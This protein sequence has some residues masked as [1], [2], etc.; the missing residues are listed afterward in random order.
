[1]TWGMYL[2]S[3]W[4]LAHWHVCPLRHIHPVRWWMNVCVCVCVCVWGGVC[5]C[6]FVCVCVVCVYV[7]MCACVCV[8]VRMCV[9]VCA[10]FTAYNMHTH[11]HTHMTRIQEGDTPQEGWSYRVLCANEPL[12]VWLFCVIVWLSCGKWSA[13]TGWRTS[14]TAW[15][16]SKRWQ[17]VAVCCNVCSGLRRRL[18]HG[19]RLLQCFTVCY[20]VLQYVAAC[21][22]RLHRRSL[23]GAKLFAAHW[24]VL[25]QIA[26]SLHARWQIVVVCC[27]VLQCV[28]ADHVVA[29]Y[30]ATNDAVCCSVLQCIASSLN[31]RWQIV[32][33]CCN[34]L[35]WLTL[36]IVS[37]PHNERATSKCVRMLQ[38]AAVCCIVLQCV[39][40]L[41]VDLIC[42]QYNEW[43]TKKWVSVLHCVAV[44]CIVLQWHILDVISG[45][46]QCVAVFC[47]SG[48]FW[49]WTV[50]HKTSVPLLTSC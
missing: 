32:V 22:S 33:V 8:H 46:L 37:G 16:L 15:S 38:C 19:G 14:L 10:V 1:M 6:V 50:S 28:A 21:R 12:I 18:L 43:T 31:T 13:D 3:T 49:T 48:T 34:V 2:R 30:T 39:A 25:Q 11:T 44:R 36:G 17:I 5:V 26:S 9:C 4:Q 27:S 29:H 35:Q 42:G 47:C 40:V 41:T 45:L 24:S 20:C 7:R 23:Q